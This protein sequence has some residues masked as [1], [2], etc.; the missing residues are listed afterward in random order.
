MP[1]DRGMDKKDVLHINNWIL[2]SHKK[3]QNNDICSNMDE[4]KDSHTEWS[5]SDKEG[6]IS[7]DI[8]YMWNLKKWYKRTYLQDRNRVTDVE[9]NLMVTSG[10]IGGGINW[11]IWHIHTTIYK[12][13][14]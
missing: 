3:E 13:D 4:T 5:K 7:Y 11:E 2:L 14:N 12:I 9:N 6:Q 1:I 8:A 10:E